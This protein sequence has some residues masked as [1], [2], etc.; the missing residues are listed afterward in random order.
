MTER[1]DSDRFMSKIHELKVD[2]EYFNEVFNGTKP[3]ELRKNDR[4]FKVHDLLKLK[5]YDR[6]TKTYSGR[7]A[8][9]EI[10]F[11]TDYPDALKP[12]YVC[13]GLKMG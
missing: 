13:L 7:W 6:E 12:G 2:P 9:A 3:F 10:T 4:N 1:P 5:E 11:I 8:W